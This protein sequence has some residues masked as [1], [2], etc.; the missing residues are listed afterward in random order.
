[1]STNSEARAVTGGRF[2]LRTLA[3]ILLG[4]MVLAA[5]FY[6]IREL[7]AALLIFSIL[8]AIA[9]IALVIFAV[10]EEAAWMAMRGIVTVWHIVTGFV[11]R[12][13]PAA[14]HV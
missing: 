12:H 9:V 5:A 4:L 10:M 6:P 2:H 14:R 8:F 7:I 13:Q 3:A 1:M 11:V